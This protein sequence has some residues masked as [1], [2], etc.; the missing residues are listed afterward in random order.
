MHL[1]TSF[2]R[3]EITVNLIVVRSPLPLMGMTM[4]TV[5]HFQLVMNSC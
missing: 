2:Y 4:V 3:I 5:I 1:W